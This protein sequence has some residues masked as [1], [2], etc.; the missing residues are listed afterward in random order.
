MHKKFEDYKSYADATINDLFSKDELK[1]AGHLQANYFNTVLF[2]AGANGKF[3]EKPLPAEAQYSP[4]FTIVPFD[5]D[6]DGNEDV[7]LCGNINHA[8]LRFGKFD[9]NYGVLLHNDRNGNFIYVNQSLSGFQLRG[10]VRSVAAI[11]NT[12]FFGINQEALRAYQ[13]K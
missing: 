13:L 6:K 10:D 3:V 8:R 7:L 1:D 11:N 4:V 9:A 2:E 12:L 5:Y